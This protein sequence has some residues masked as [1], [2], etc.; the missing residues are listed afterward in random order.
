V[1]DLE[2]KRAKLILQA[3]RVGQNPIPE[4]PEI[5]LLSLRGDPV[6]FR[7]SED[8]HPGRRVKILQVN[9]DQRNVPVEQMLLATG[10][11]DN[12]VAVF[13]E[14]RIDLARVSCRHSALVI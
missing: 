14:K 5:I 2:R 12:R 4:R 11:L 9:A 8:T 1:D 10:V 7:L 13:L 6:S 3:P